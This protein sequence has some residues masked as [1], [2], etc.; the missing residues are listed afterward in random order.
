M[1]EK[2]KKIDEILSWVFMIAAFIILA[3]ALVNA[4]QHRDSN[5]PNYVFGYG[6]IR[7][8]SGS[9]E[10][11]FAVNGIAIIKEVDDM[12]D[13]AVDDIVTFRV[14]SNDGDV[15]NVTHRI[16]EISEDGIIT[17][18]GDNNQVADMYPLTINHIDSK[19]V[20][21]FN[22]SAWVFDKLIW[23]KQHPITAGCFGLSILLFGFTFHFIRK[24]KEEDKEEIKTAEDETDDK[25]TISDTVSNIQ[26]KIEDDSDILHTQ[27]EENKENTN[28]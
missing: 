11:T 14:Y 27:S 18:K 19:V 17:T 5:E 10:P 9:M 15:N 2:F 20:A 24:S 13:I 1:K 8:I 16:V 21:I 4:F 26:K 28:A 23:L 12:N 3:A 6:A 22:E 25:Q 7:A